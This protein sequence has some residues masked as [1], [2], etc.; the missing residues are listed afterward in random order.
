[1]FVVVQ[2]CSISTGIF[3]ECTVGPYVK[4]VDTEAVKL[5]ERLIE[6]VDQRVDRLR[7][8]KKLLEMEKF[9]TTLKKDSNKSVVR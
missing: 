6:K 4:C 5:N 7:K 2:I 3:K 9:L 1:M 8:L